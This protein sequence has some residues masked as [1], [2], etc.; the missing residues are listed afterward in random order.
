M[1][2]KADFETRNV[3]DDTLVVLSEQN[4]DN[5]EKVLKLNRTAAEIL[6]MVSSGMSEPEAASAMAKKYTI[7]RERAASDVKKVLTQLAEQG[8]LEL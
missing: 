4:A 5:V 6:Q 2:L 3:G 7:E 1:K 8:I